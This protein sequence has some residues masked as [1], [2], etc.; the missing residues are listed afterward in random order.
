MA[1]GALLLGSLERTL[2]GGEPLRDNVEFFVAE[3]LQQG[4]DGLLARDRPVSNALAPLRG[5]AQPD[6]AAVAGIAVL[7]DDPLSREP[8]HQDRHAAFR[9]PGQP[10]QLVDRDAGV[11][12]D[13][14]YGGKGRAVPGKRELPA[15]SQL[16][17]LAAETP[18]HVPEQ[19]SDLAL[20]LLAA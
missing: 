14:P 5:D 2:Q 7:A 11:L 1:S 13:L 17:M 19:L 10:G 12:A 4:A 15:G 20:R 9:Q 16:R 6:K 3:R 8:A 18:H